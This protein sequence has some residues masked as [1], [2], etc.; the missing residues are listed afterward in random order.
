MEKQI[1]KQQSISNMEAEVTVICVDN[2]TLLAKTGVYIAQAMAIALYCD[3]KIKAHPDNMV[4]LVPMGALQ[5][6]SYVK[7]TR[8]LNEILSA[9]KENYAEAM[10]HPKPAL[11]PIDVEN[12]DASHWDDED[13]TECCCIL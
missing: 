8:D 12:Y 9:L 6:T 10:T 2:T 3:E 5:G 4:A 1:E 7:P 13:E 11:H